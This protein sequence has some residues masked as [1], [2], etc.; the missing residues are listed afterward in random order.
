MHRDLVLRFVEL[1]CLLMAV[2]AP[3]WVEGIWLEVLKKPQSI[4]LARFPKVP[5][6]DAGLSAARKYISQTSSSVNATESLQMKKM[7]KGKD[8]SFDPKK[9][10]KLTI[11]MSEKFPDWQSALI[12][13]F[14]ESWDPVTKSVDDKALMGHI[15]KAQRKRSI[16]FVQAL[17]KRLQSGETESAVLGRKL[18]FDEKRVLILMIDTLMRSASLTQIQV[19]KVQEGESEGVDLITG[20]KVGNMPPVAA[21]AVPG[22]PTFF[23]V[24]A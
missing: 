13:L 15:D 4:Q 20:D 19:L 1:Q 2:I 3:H 17:K 22:S 12:G 16:P 11:Y 23:F 7:A 18:P 10:K 5:E 9:P 21:S 24:N 6:V 8:I 14:Q